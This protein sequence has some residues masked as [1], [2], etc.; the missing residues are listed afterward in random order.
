VAE[1]AVASDSAPGASP[2]LGYVTITGDLEVSQGL[3]SSRFSLQ[4]SGAS[5]LAL[6]SV[7]DS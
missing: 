3:L 1:M 7:T 4:A 2:V 5:S 6:S